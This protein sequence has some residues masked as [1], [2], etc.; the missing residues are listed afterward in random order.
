MRF[1]PPGSAVHR[2]MRRTW[3]DWLLT[4]VHVVLRRWPCDVEV[5]LPA[6]SDPVELEHVLAALDANRRLS[7]DDRAAFRRALRDLDLLPREEPR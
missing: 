5:Y 3:G 1:T 6:L 7:D 4:D 2:S